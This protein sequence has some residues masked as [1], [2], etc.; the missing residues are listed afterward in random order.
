MPRER[1]NAKCSDIASAAHTMRTSSSDNRTHSTSEPDGTLPANADHLT[2]LKHL[3]MMKRNQVGNVAELEKT[4]IHGIIDKNNQMMCEIH[5]AQIAVINDHYQLKLKESAA[6]IRRLNDC[7]N[8]LRSDQIVIRNHLKEIIPVQKRK[9]QRL[10]RLNE[11]NVRL[12]TELIMMKRRLNQNRNDREERDSFSDPQPITAMTANICNSDN[13][14]NHQ[15]SEIEEAHQSVDTPLQNEISIQLTTDNVAEQHIN[16]TSNERDVT[17]RP[18]SLHLEQEVNRNHKNTLCTPPS[19]CFLPKTSANPNSDRVQ[20][21]ETE[22]QK[23]EE[24][25]ADTLDRIVLDNKLPTESPTPKTN[26]SVATPPSNSIPP[27]IPMSS[28]HI[29]TDSVMEHDAIPN[30]ESM[31]SESQ[32]Q[33]IPLN[34]MLTKTKSSSRR[35]SKR[36]QSR[37]IVP[38][39]NKTISWIGSKRKRKGITKSMQNDWTNVDGGSN[40]TK[41]SLRKRKR[42]HNQFGSLCDCLVYLSLS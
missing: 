11:E 22:K 27:E 14:P 4:L 24:G 30:I 31:I 8:R 29:E 39:I 5:E 40:C 16:R 20:P 38:S 3:L 10:Q 12:R 2:R 13:T 33:S 9:S 19:F 28:Q 26:D 15:E 21:E 42:K 23:S 17:E 18:I 34:P 41:R 36:L 37:S 6:A 25:R 35:H 32:T 1:Q 7:N